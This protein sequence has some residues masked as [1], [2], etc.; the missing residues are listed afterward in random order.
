MNRIDLTGTLAMGT[1]GIVLVVLI[2]LLARFLRKPQNQHPMDGQPEQN[3]G[4]R[5]DTR[6]DDAVSAAPP[7]PRI[8]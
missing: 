5:L 4:A 8:P 7:V 6:K 2:V 1:I 3:I